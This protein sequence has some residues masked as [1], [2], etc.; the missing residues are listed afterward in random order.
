MR[1]RRHVFVESGRGLLGKPDLFLFAQTNGGGQCALRFDCRQLAYRKCNSRA[2]HTRG[3]NNWAGAQLT[4]KLSLHWFVLT[5]FENSSRLA[6]SEDKKPFLFSTRFLGSSKSTL[7]RRCPVYFSLSY[8]IM[9]AGS[10]SVFWVLAPAVPFF[11]GAVWNCLPAYLGS[12]AVEGATANQRGHLLSEDMC[13]LNLGPK[14][15]KS[16]RTNLLHVIISNRGV[17]RDVERAE[18]TDCPQFGR[19]LITHDL[20]RSATNVS[21]ARKSLANKVKAPWQPK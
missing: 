19:I 16:P 1:R 17:R 10:K 18:Q 6:L 9:K 2:V 14:I 15:C 11:A 5:V 7:Y 4:F 3:P 12:G 21:L 13:N 8:S 20:L